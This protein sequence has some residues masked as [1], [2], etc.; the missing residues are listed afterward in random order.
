MSKD[1]GW[2]SVDEVFARAV[3]MN[4]IRKQV[5]AS[6]LCFVF[7]KF[8]KEEWGESILEEIKEIIF[9]SQLLKLK[10]DS[11]PLRNEIKLAELDIMQYINDYFGKEVVSRVIF[12]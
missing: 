5:T 1:R 2:E 6:N 4:F 3:N 11:A 7:E 10:V 9:K 12:F 8:A